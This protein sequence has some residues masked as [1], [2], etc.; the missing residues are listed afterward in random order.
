MEVVDAVAETWGADR[1]GYRIAP[2]GVFNDMQDSDP[3]TTFGYLATKLSERELA[4]IHVVEAFGD[5]ERDEAT[6]QAVRQAFAGPYIANGGYTPQLAR[7]RIASGMADAVAFGMLYISN[8]DLR[9]RI[10][11]E[12]ELAQ[13]DQATFYGGTEKG[14][15][16]YPPLA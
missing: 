6:A 15:T 9:E 4:Y 5:Q 11:K 1:V 13:P 2:T 8:P 3:V 7:E 12:A 14:Y 16:D 10:E